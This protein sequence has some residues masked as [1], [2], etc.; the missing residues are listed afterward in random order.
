MTKIERIRA[1]IEKRT[2]GEQGY[3]SEYTERGYRACAID[4]LAIFDSLQEEPKPA[5]F[6]MKPTPVPKFSIG[7]R[8]KHKTGLC[9]AF[10]IDR[11]VDMTYVGVNGEHVG[12]AVQDNWELV[13][14]SELKTDNDLEKA[15]HYYVEGW[16][17]ERDMDMDAY[18]MDAQISKE[19][20]I[21]GANWQKQQMMKDA[22]D[23]WYDEETGEYSYE[24]PLRN[25]RTVK[26]KLIIVKEG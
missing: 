5:G 15:A 18:P 2:H 10:K 16:Y 8:T 6:Y 19:E 3:A 17:K 20:F 4:L 23:G 26:A 24:Q 13:E 22:I 1:E 14:D 11:I 7:D 21:A 12:I 25:F 9:P